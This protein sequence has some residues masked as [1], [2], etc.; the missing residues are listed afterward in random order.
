MLKTKLF[1]NKKKYLRE[2]LIIFLISILVGFAY[3]EISEQQ[4]P[5]IYKPFK[6]EGG[7]KLSL[8]DVQ[9]IHKQRNALFIDAR[10]K[11]E[12]N[13]GHIPDAINIPANLNRSKKIDLWDEIPKNLQ[14]II[15]C[16]DPQCHFAERLA[17]E[18]QYMKFTSV[19]VF[20]GGWDAWNSIKIN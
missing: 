1:N 7:R 10:I 5:L 13:A 2:I 6:I 20:D 16:E 15:Y 9:R 11:E 12:Y 14:I 3:N 19:V 4:L 8:T 17:K 18:M